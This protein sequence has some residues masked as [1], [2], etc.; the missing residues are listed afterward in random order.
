MQRIC[1]FEG[2]NRLYYARDLCEAHYQQRRSG[3]ELSPIWVT[4]SSCIFEGCERPYS[5]KGL[6]NIHYGQLAA[7]GELKPIGWRAISEIC[8]FEGCDRRSKTKD[9]CG[10]HY[11]QFH[12]GRELKPFRVTGGWRRLSSGYVVRSVPHG[13]PIQQHREVMEK[14]LGR[15]LTKGENVHHLNG[16][17]YDNRIENLELWSTVQPPGQRIPD[18]VAWAIEILAMYAPGELAL[19]STLKAA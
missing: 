12:K 7:T 18:K 17:R 3:R 15:S 6:C 16:C 2:C 8:I 4:P 11:S 13:M 9:L 14:H 19:R 1:T 10:G 5:A